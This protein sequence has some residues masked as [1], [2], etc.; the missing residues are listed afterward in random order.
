MHYLSR[1]Q[2]SRGDE[3]LPSSH[4]QHHTHTASPT[5][6][7]MTHQEWFALGYGGDENLTRDDEYSSDDCED[8]IVTDR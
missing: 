5:T 7:T 2:C 1:S 8:M 6:D 4:H 3:L